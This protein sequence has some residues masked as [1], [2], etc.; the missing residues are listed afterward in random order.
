MLVLVQLRETV[1]RQ[2][3]LHRR[4]GLH[5]VEVRDLGEEEM[6]HHVPVRDVV[7]QLVLQKKKSFY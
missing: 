6:V 5:Q 7:V 1:L 4:G 2:P 3:L